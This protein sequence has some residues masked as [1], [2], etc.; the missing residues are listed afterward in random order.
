MRSDAL[1]LDSMCLLTRKFCLWAHSSILFLC[2]KYL[3]TSNLTR[4]L[5]NMHLCQCFIHRFFT[6]NYHIKISIK[7]LFQNCTSALGW[8]RMT[9][10]KLKKIM[11]NS[12][13]VAVIKVIAEQ[14]NWSSRWGV[15]GWL[16]RSTKEILYLKL[17]PY[18]FHIK[19]K[20]T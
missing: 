13:D 4:F 10:G 5:Y 12:L 7:A 2:I 1:S 18:C 8:N 6:Q 15:G 9:R 11:A 20:N 17:N 16:P 14:H 3:P 19:I